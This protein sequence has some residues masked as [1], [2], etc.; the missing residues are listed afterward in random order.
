MDLVAGADNIIV[1]MTHASKDGE[2]KLLFERILRW[3]GEIHEL[4]YIALRYFNA[5]GATAQFGEDHRVETHLIP[6]VLAVAL[7]HHDLVDRQ[8]APRHLVARLVA[9]PPGPTTRPP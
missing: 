5:A 6:N 9:N 4:R 8:R 3:Y 2:S 1:T 7:A